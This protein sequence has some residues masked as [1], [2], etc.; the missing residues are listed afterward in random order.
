M[1]I[2]VSAIVY[3]KGENA[4]MREESILFDKRLHAIERTLQQIL[5]AQNLHN[6]NLAVVYKRVSLLGH[7]IEAVSQ[8][9][10][11]RV[12]ETLRAEIDYT[13]HTEEFLA[14]FDKDPEEFIKSYGEEIFK[15]LRADRENGLRR[16]G[17]LAPAR[18]SA[19]K[20][21]Q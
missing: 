18:A 8:N 1:K 6:D 5:D 4:M 14:L 16:F 20:K 2:E 12:T 7:M 15:I 11:P 17:K 10:E 9:K 13:V 21:L 19:K 3:L